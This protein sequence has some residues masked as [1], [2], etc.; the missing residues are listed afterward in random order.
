MNGFSLTGGIVSFK[1]TFY[2]GKQP[3]D[4][5]DKVGEF[6][7]EGKANSKGSYYITEVE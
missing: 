7:K 3:I 4:L 5:I 6:L 1:S 2:R